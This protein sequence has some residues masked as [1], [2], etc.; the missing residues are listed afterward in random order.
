MYILSPLEH[1]QKYPIA[2]LYFLNSDY[3]I[4]NE[5]VFLL[6]FILLIIVYFLSLVLKN[7]ASF[8][9]IPNNRWQVLTSYLF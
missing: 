9:L 6:L 8:Y 5:T 1:F 3:S 4:T 7:E 2:S